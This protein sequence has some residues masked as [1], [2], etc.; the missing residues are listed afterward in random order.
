M[1]PLAS[2]FSSR[3]WLKDAKVL[4]NLGY[5]L[6][7]T[8][9]THCLIVS[10]QPD[11]K[12]WRRNTDK[13]P[14]IVVFYRSSCDRILKLCI[15]KLIPV[16]DQEDL[17]KTVVGQILFGSFDHLPQWFSLAERLQFEGDILVPASQRFHLLK[18]LLFCD[19]SLHQQKHCCLLLAKLPPSALLCLSRTRTIPPTCQ[20]YSPPCVIP[21]GWPSRETTRIRLENASEMR[22]LF[23]SGTAPN[24]PCRYRFSILFESEILNSSSE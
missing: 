19:F 15:R 1:F 23:T 8:S 12:L 4:F 24:A 7:V 9:Q 11:F 2:C 22:V 14:V 10:T 21:T 18:V 5:F 17:V 3:R 20:S 13:K 16:E 6:V